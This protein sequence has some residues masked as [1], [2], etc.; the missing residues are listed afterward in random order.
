MANIKELDKQYVMNTYGRHNLTVERGR[1][2]KLYSDDGK[3]YIDFG[4]GIGTLSLGTADE[5]YIQA[6]T[7]QLY[8]TQHVSNYFTCEPVAKLAEKI[9]TLSGY[10]KV[11]FANSGAEANEGAIKLA[12]KY[13]FDKYGKGRSTIITFNSSF[14][15]RTITTLAATGQ[16]VFHDFFFP[17]T[18]GFK[19][20][21]YNDKDALLSNLT[22]DVCAVMFECI[23][24][25]GGV[26]VM[27]KEFAL[28]LAEE[29]KKRDILLICDEIQ[30][31]IARTGKLFAFE[32]F[33]IKPDIFTL[34]K[35][36]CGGMPC[37]AFVASEK[38]SSVLTK[39]QHGST[40]GGNPVSCA[41]GNY[42]MNIVSAP[43]FLEEV[44]AKGE[45][46]MQKLRDLGKE[47][48][49]E[50]RGMG[51]M[52]GIK[53]SLVP[54]EVSTKALE[55]GLIVLTAGKDVVRLLPPLVIS[56]E[57]IDEGVEILAQ[58]F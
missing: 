22:D 41:A 45:Y 54:G 11:F 17:F 40:F 55:N 46:L 29:C 57:E 9:C 20:S 56:Y 14:H 1:G 51:L 52:V 19:Y 31:G 10:D 34:A 23:Q 25:E 58:L 7:E 24:G 12:R 39:G 35:G 27:D 32:N 36:L 43:S 8:K 13:S 21:P 50:V 18:E 16:D 5:G 49:L 48:I 38:C 15:G 2:C 44:K 30:T 3:E 6:I 47:T 4:S 28:F 53:T 42:V 33:D 26:N 37:G